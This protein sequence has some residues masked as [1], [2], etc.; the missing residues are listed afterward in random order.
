[1]RPAT[2]PRH[3]DG[4]F[5]F[6]LDKRRANRI[7]SIPIMWITRETDYAIRCML[8]LSG[9]GGEVVVMD[10]I[11]EA[12]D[13]PRSFLAKILQKL[14]K[15]N[16][17]TSY[18]GVRGG[19]SLARAP[20]DITLLDVIVAIQG[21][22]ALNQCAVDEKMCDLSATCVVHPL[23]ILLKDDFSEV[24]GRYDFERLATLD[25][26]GRPDSLIS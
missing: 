4:L 8:H 12:R 23:W 14:S 22:I 18:R 20:R 17:V 13:I 7:N 6:P 19:F 25:K 15:E 16:L 10:E 9:R 2:P 26:E 21:T 11:S 24:L 5:H 3:L 1:M